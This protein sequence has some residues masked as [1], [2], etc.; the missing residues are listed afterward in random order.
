MSDDNVSTVPLAGGS[1][2]R[3]VRR[4]RTTRYAFGILRNRFEIRPAQREPIIRWLTWLHKHEKVPIGEI[5]EMC[6]TCR[7]S[8][9]FYNKSKSWLKSGHPLLLKPNTND[10][11]HTSA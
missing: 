4:Y 10:M 9:D 2:Q 8:D 1:D 7:D 6:K 3:L 11:P 5:C